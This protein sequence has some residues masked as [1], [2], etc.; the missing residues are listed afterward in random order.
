MG[1]VAGKRRVSCDTSPCFA[2]LAEGGVLWWACAR[3]QLTQALTR[4]IVLP[5]MLV[6]L[7]RI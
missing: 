7:V 6:W 3:G 1:V 5:G 2:G 4:L